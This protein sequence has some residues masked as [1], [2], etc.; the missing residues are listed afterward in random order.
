[1]FRTTVCAALAL[2]TLSTIT[3]GAEQPCSDR[4]GDVALWPAPVPPDAPHLDLLR[5]AVTRTSREVVATTHTAGGTG[6][7]TWELRFAYTPAYEF[8]VT[9]RR[10]VGLP[11]ASAPDPRVPLPPV[12]EVIHWQRPRADGTQ[13]GHSKPIAGASATVTG[14]GQVTVRF[15]LRSLGAATPARGT[16]ARVLSAY[17]WQ[18]PAAGVRYWD[19]V[20]CGGPAS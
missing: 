19:R 13:I 4:R 10:D 15:P 3:A 7:G 16:R 20:I 2:V 6:N 12:A 11:W 5:F 14:N 1:M 8:I 17:A 9:A 18:E